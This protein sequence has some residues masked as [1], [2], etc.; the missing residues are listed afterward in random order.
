MSAA[1]Q[2]LAE[3]FGPF[4]ELCDSG[5]RDRWLAMRRS[6]IGASEAAVIVGEH[7]RLNLA[8]L[9]AEKRGLLPQT[10]DTREFLEWGLRLE[11]VMIEAYSSS[12]Y[13]GRKARKAGKLLRSTEHPWAL[14]TL[15]A[16]TLHPQH[17]LIPLELKSTDWARDAWEYGTP[18]D[19]WWQAQHQALVTGAPCVSVACMLG[20]HKLVWEDVPRDEAAIRRLTVHGPDVWAL[21]RSDRE[22]PGPYDDV[23]FKALWP[24][25]DG[26][27]IELDERFGAMDE[28]RESLK[29]GVKLATTRLDEIDAE[30]RAALKGATEG[31]L[32]NGRVRYSLKT[33]TRK[34]HVVK[35]SEFRVL[36]RH[37]PKTT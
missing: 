36:R 28:E 34:E 5:D 6:G 13:A 10:D 4:E 33:Q 11:P 31:V 18:P 15:D 9:V 22:P 3:G 21:V 27:T 37:E 35:A 19:Y 26:T 16:W 8:H 2:L 32:P 14:A 1:P 23:T 29:Q 24:S 12:R 17:G 25:D 30:L 20:P 7:S